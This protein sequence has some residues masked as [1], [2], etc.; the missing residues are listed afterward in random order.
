LENFYPV[1]FDQSERGAIKDPRVTQTRRLSWDRG[2]PTALL[3]SKRVGKHPRI[4]TLSQKCPFARDSLQQGYLYIGV[5]ELWQKVAQWQ[6]CL[7]RRSSILSWAKSIPRDTRTACEQVD[8]PGFLAIFPRI[9]KS[10]VNEMV[11]S[12]FY[13]LNETMG[14]LYV[15]VSGSKDFVQALPRND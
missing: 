11:S 15:Q 4:R 12:W 14:K 3:H 7:T 1:S 8:E 13:W 9:H 6:Y 2:F 5:W 10:K